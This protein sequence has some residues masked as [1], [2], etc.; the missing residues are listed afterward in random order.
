MEPEQ[1]NKKILD[2]VKEVT[3]TDMVTI[4]KKL[5]RELVRG[6][7]SGT[8]FREYFY[9]NCKSDEIAACVNEIL[10]AC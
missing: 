8:P 7:I 6:A 5:D 1:R 3:H 4:L 9:T 10:S 2:K